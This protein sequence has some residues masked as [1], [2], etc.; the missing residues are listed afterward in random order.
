[1]RV[2]SPTV[3]LAEYIDAVRARSGDR[4]STAR[5]QTNGD[6]SNEL[7]NKEPRTR[8]DRSHQFDIEDV[9]EI[10]VYTTQGETLSG[11]HCSHGELMSIYQY[12][13]L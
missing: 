5:I 10:L 3:L 13:H 4:L 9:K 8:T 2:S 7:E 12:R 11:L 1:M 6:A